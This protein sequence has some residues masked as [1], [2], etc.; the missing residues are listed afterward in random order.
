[1]YFNSQ[2]QESF[3]LA[4]KVLKTCF[5]AYLM[6]KTDLEKVAFLVCCWIHGVFGKQNSQQN[7]VDIFN[8]HRIRTLWDISFIL[9]RNT[10][11]KITKKRVFQ[12]IF[13]K[14]VSLW[15]V[16]WRQYNKIEYIYKIH[17]F[18]VTIGN[19]SFVTFLIL[20]KTVNIYQH[21]EELKSIIMSNKN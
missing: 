10:A 3:S 4:F 18:V 14:V 13:T 12:L 9:F 15:K 8:F 19:L 17:A 5:V 21:S 16:F 7:K 1:M 11:V 6:A 20:W 2:F